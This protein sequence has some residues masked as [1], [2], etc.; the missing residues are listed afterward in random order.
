[1]AVVTLRVNNASPTVALTGGV[2]TGKSATTERFARLGVPVFDA[3]IIAR[4]LVAPGQPALV[5]ITVAFDADMLTPAGELNRAR[6]RALVFEDKD[7]RRRLEA[8]LHPRVRAALIEQVRAC[9][10]P[11]CILAIPLLTENR[12]DYEWVNRILVTDAPR[13][14]QL[15]RLA[16]RTG[17]DAVLAERMLDAQATRA[18]RFAL[19]HDVIDNTGPLK[20][21]D[22]AVGRLHQ[23]YLA[24]AATWPEA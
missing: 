19:A 16:R 14:T 23:R 2:A 12:G 24:L 15:Q 3:D 22:A 20:A 13:E 21:L 17:I 18:A 9:K 10:A 6:L 1:L 4:N 7:A 8:I 5:E 11:Y